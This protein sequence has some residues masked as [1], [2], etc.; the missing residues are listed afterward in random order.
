M[1]WVIPNSIFTSQAITLAESTGVKLIGRNELGELIL[2]A[3]NNNG[4][5]A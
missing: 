4:K 5:L 2:N 1:A 3:K